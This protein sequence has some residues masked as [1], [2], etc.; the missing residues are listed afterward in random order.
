MRRGEQ[1][2]EDYN[3]FEMEYNMATPQCI[4]VIELIT[5]ALDTD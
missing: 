5:Q 3:F 4:C 1:G 2:G